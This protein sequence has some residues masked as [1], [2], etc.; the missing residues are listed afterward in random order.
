MKPGRRSIGIGIALWSWSQLAAAAELT[1]QA[2]SGCPGDEEVQA[3]LTRA[4]GTE[5]G[6]RG[7]VRF[8]AVAS[9]RE[10]GFD[11]TLT[12]HQNGAVQERRIK[13]ASCDA[14]VD[15]LV[16]QVSLAIHAAEGEPAS[17]ETSA[18][19]SAPEPERDSELEPSP[20]APPAA[21]R[22][23]EAAR[24]ETDDAGSRVSVIIGAGALLETGA[25]PEAAFGAEALAG[26]RLGNFNLFALGGILPE[27]HMAL[28]G[29]AGGAFELWFGG[30]ELCYVPAGSTFQLGGCAGLE[31]GS[32]GAT[33]WNVANPRESR[34][35]WVAGRVA[36]WL[37]ARPASSTWAFFVSP[38]MSLPFVRQPFELT[39]LGIVH[40]PA[41]LG[42]RGTAG[43]E[44]EIR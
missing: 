35:L 36:A 40:E 42:F 5:L 41:A 12:T 9:A 20:A 30:A 23:Q 38:G 34:S 13:A 21:R 24:P 10:G 29:S 14:L 8:D 27:Q 43:L 6:E 25:F 26:A 15:A 4:L 33:G 3:R 18:E 7:D 31:I 17:A 19:G 37:A 39:S 11:L 44:L 16:A 2:P 32:L 22:T 28:R 1:W